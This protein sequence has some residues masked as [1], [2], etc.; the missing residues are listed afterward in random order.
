[1]KDKKKFFA[2]IP[3]IG[4][5]IISGVIFF[6]TLKTGLFNWKFYISMSGFI[7]LLGLTFWFSMLFHK[8]NF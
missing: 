7:I 2:L 4:F 1:M 5:T 3:L 6:N 8:R